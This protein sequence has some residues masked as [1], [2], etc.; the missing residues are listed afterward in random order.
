MDAWMVAILVVA[1]IA[2]CGFL[3]VKQMRSEEMQGS[4][5]QS[6]EKNG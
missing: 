4:D 1:A 2:V 3:L 5:R 6:R